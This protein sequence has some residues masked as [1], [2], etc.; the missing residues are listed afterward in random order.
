MIL[1]ND[2]SRFFL[3]KSK[4]LL[5]FS[6]C[7]ILHFVVRNVGL[8]ALMQKAEA[9]SSRG[10]SLTQGVISRDDL[11]V[12][13]SAVA[14]M[15]SALRSSSARGSS[16]V[17]AA[18]PF[19]Q[20]SAGKEARGSSSVRGKSQAVGTRRF[21]PQHVKWSGSALFGSPRHGNADQERERALL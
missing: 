13:V 3:I 5:K 16:S 15:K 20:H 9:V 21:A 12:S 7:Y 18:S 8:K 4:Y 11:S 10:V 17:S 2:S 14:D 19:A 6:R 1:P